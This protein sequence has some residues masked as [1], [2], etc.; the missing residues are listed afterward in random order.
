MFASP[1]P[2]LACPL[3]VVLV[4]VVVAVVGA[5]CGGPHGTVDGGPDPSGPL[6]TRSSASPPGSSRSPSSVSRSEA[7]D[8]AG[9]VRREIAAAQERYYRSFLAAVEAPGDRR[10][11]D[12]LLAS[13]T[14]TGAPRQNVTAWL[15]LLAR[16]GYAARPGAGNR[17]VIE[18]IEVPTA[19][20]DTV[21]ATVCGYDD[22]VIFDARRRA[23]DGSEI[24]VDDIPLRERTLFT[25]VKHETWQIDRVTTTDSWNGRDGCPPS[26]RS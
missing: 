16:R 8:P 25:W 26:K 13:Y 22:G 4:F 6:S 12:G 10:G 15:A 18:K 21:V 2:R 24:V 19:A 11:V 20:L 23:P 17:Y 7:V 14:A 3:S 9:T 5:A 1:C